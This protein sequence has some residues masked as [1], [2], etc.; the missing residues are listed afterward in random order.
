[1]V[2][3]CASASVPL[4]RRRGHARSQVGGIRRTHRRRVDR[5]HEHRAGRQQ[6][7]VSNEQRDLDHESVDEHGLRD[8]GPLTG[9]AGHCE[10]LRYD[11]SRAERTH[12]ATTAHLLH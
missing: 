6:E 12:L 10:P 8:H 7:A 3:R 5:E 1:M 2:R 9:V 11:L 4:V